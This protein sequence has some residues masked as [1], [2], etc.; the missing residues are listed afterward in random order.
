MQ[1]NRSRGWELTAQLDAIKLL[2]GERR[3]GLK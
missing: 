2:E 3:A 1:L